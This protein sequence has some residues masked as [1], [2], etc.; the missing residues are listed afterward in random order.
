MMKTQQLQQMRMMMEAALQ[1]M[2]AADSGG[3]GSF[4]GGG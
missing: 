4:R 1:K 2:A 3:N